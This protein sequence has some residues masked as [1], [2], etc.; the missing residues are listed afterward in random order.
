MIERNF[1]KLINKLSIK[2]TDLDVKTFYYLN[3]CVHM[4]LALMTVGR[5]LF[6]PLYQLAA[7]ALYA[8]MGR[9]FKKERFKY[10]YAV[11]LFEMVGHA[12]IV[13][14]FTGDTC[15]AEMYIIF[16]VIMMSYVVFF[17]DTF[18]GR[19]LF[20]L[21]AMVLCMGA[22][23]F[24]H[25]VLIYLESPIYDAQM[26]AIR[27]VLSMTLSM[28]MLCVL[29]VWVLMQT[30]RNHSQMEQLQADNCRLQTCND[31]D[32]LTQVCSRKHAQFILDERY[33]TFCETGKAFTIAIGDIDF[34]KSVNDQYGHES[35]DVVLSRLGRIFKS[36][37]RE[38]DVVSRWGGEEFLFIFDANVET[39]IDVLERLRQ[40]IENTVIPVQDSAISVTMTFGCTEIRAGE[41]ILELVRRA[42]SYLY[43]GKKA[44]RNRVVC[45]KCFQELTEGGSIA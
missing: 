34:F 41:T 10:Y 29:F 32:F 15:H 16:Q 4:I 40:L 18:L 1:D 28:S 33:R 5:C 23:F 3:A 45:R 35:G 36:S 2:G 6:F 14:L 8:Y 21:V 37:I 19:M 11:S 9:S 38:S 24:L 27:S 26:G 31:T 43:C 30:L 7:M 44:G 25:H 42:D 20:C 22:H 12:V 13:W 17:F 39:S